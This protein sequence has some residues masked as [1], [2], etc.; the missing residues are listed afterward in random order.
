MDNI[1][2]VNL[3]FELTYFFSLNDSKK[4]HYLAERLRYGVIT[5]A[6]QLGWDTQ[7]LLEPFEIMRNKNYRNHF[8]VKRPKLSPDKKR[9]AYA[10]LEVELYDIS[11]YL[12]VEDRKNNILIKEIIAKTEPFFESVTYYMKELKWLSNDEVALYTRA[13]KTKYNSVKL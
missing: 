1:Y 3:P 2:Y 13:H 11:L 12:V 7:P 6:E 5:L 8:K 9:K 4:K 10:Y